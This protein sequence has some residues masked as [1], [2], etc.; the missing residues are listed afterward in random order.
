MPVAPLQDMVEDLLPAAAQVSHL[1]KSRRSIRTYQNKPVEREA[2]MELLDIA[3]YAPTGHNAQPVRW[4]VFEKAEDVRRL[5]GLT[6]DGMRP[7]VESNS[8]IAQAFHLDRVVDAWDGGIDRVLR[9]APHLIVAYGPAELP[10]SESS[11][12]IALTYLEIAAYARGLGACWAGYFNFVSSFYAPLQE[13][14]AL[15]EGHACFGAMMIGRPE[16]GY[17]RIP[18]RNEAVVTWR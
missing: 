6:V 3:R 1:L 17:H 10:V 4:L 11:C 18:A 5:A 15:P 9:G 13:A 7:L 8:E 14:L 12:T 2:I 16:Y